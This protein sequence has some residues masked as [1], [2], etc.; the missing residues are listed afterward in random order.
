MAKDTRADLTKLVDGYNDMYR[1]PLQYAQTTYLA[2]IK[3]QGRPWG[4][5]RDAR[6]LANKPWNKMDVPI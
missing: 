6:N 2:N 1:D 3:S 4:G 5:D